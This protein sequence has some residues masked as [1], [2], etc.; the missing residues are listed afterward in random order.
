[1]YSVLELYL[2]RTLV[3]LWMVF[4]LGLDWPLVELLVGPWL[5]FGWPFVDLWPFVC[6]LLTFGL[7]LGFCW[8]N[9]GL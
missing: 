9:V 1:M 6:H 4:G 2:I 3:D 8:P 5:A 7:C